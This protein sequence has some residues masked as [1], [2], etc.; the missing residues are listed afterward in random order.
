MQDYHFVEE[1]LFQI[2]HFSVL[3]S[4]NE[5]LLV[6]RHV[7]CTRMVL[8]EDCSEAKENVKA[9]DKMMMSAAAKRP[10]AESN[11]ESPDFSNEMQKILETFGCE[12]KNRWKIRKPDLRRQRLNR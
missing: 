10:A 11:D 8:Y 4:I 12:Y 3:W 1:W 9:K 2:R 7:K 6:A 5:F